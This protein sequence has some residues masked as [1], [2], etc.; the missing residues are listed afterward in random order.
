[1]EELERKDIQGI[2]LSSYSHLYWAFYV[3]LQIQEPG[4]AR[5]GLSAVIDRVTTAEGKDGAINIL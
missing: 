2:L 3:L 1:M 4:A 5:R